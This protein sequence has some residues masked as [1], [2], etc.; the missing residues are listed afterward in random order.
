MSTNKELSASSHLSAPRGGR[1]RYFLEKDYF[2]DVD[3]PSVRRDMAFFELAVRITV[4]C[5]AQWADRYLARPCSHRDLVRQ[6]EMPASVVEREA[7]IDDLFDWL[8][9]L[10]GPLSG[11]VLNLYQ[12]DTVLLEQ[13]DGMASGTLTITDTQFTELQGCWGTHDLPRDLYYP[14]SDERTAVDPMEKFGGIIRVQQ[15]YSPRRWARRVHT[16]LDAVPIP[17][18]EERVASFL[19]ALST[20]QQA[21]WLRRAQLIEPGRTHDPALTEERKDITNLDQAVLRLALRIKAREARLSDGAHE[22]HS[23]KLPEPAG[24][25]GMDTS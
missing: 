21:L 20:F 1:S 3:L 16:Q 18:E 5:V 6:G 22:R 23:E 7:L 10:P 14:A 9:A 17:S 24:D 19:T 8:T 11:H 25:D 12:G 4:R 13:G 2:F 15:R